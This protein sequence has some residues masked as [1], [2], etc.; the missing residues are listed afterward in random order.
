[1]KQKA[2]YDVKKLENNMSAYSTNDVP[3]SIEEIR[4][5][6]VNSEKAFT[7][8][9]N[10]DKELDANYLEIKHDDDLTIEGLSGMEKITYVA[11]ANAVSPSSIAEEI[12]IESQNGGFEVSGYEALSESKQLNKAASGTKNVI[13]YKD[14]R[15]VK[16]DGHVYKNLDT[17]E[18][19][20]LK[21]GNV[22]LR[23]ALGI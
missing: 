19:R 16:V 4:N 18:V 21:E 9:L 8:I 3:S 2:V 22:L 10:N 7:V 1:M 12:Q 17:V 13:K 23:K 14:P 11:E 20:G 15:F 6:E 5:V